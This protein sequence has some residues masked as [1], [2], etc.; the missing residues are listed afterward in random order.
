VAGEDLQPLGSPNGRR[1][2]LLGGAA[3]FVR[4][5]AEALRR[6]TEPQVV[7]TPEEEEE[8]SERERHDKLV[9][10]V[11]DC[12]KVGESA[13]QEQVTREL[14]DLNFELDQWPKEY[15]DERKGGF[16]PDGHTIPAKPCLEINKLDQPIGQVVNE[17]RMARLSI[18]IKPRGAGASKDVAMV[19][20]GLIRA[21]EV[22]SRAQIARLW[23]LDRAVKCGR[24][25]YRIAKRY[26]NDGDFDLDLVIERILNQHSV[27]FDPFAKEPDWSDGEWCVIFSDLPESEYRRRYPKSNLSRANADQLQTLGN[28]QPAWISGEVGKRAFRVAEFYY[29]VHEEVERVFIDGYGEAFL[30]DVPPQL[31]DRIRLRRKVDARHVEWCI[32]NAM[33]VLDEEAW[34]GR[35]IPVIPV[36]G[37]EYNVNGKRSWRGIISNAKDAQRSYNVMRSRQVE[38]IGLASLSTWVMAE[39]QDEGY[40]EQWDRANTSSFVRLIYKPT[41]FE[42][43]LTPA[44]SRDTAEPAI[45]AITQ[46]VREADNDIKATTGRYDPSLGRARAD[47]S[48]KAIRELKTQG[49]TGTSNYLANL[50]EYSMTYEGKVLNDMLEYVYDRPGRIVRLLGE[51]DEEREVMLNQPYQ[52][53]ATA[54]DAKQ[55]TPVP[56]AQFNP[57][58]HHFYNLKDGGQ[59]R[60]YVTVGPSQPSAREDD[61]Q[62]MN[63]LATAAP[64]LVPIYAD[65]WVRSNDSRVASQVADRLRRANP[66]AQQD[67]AAKKTNLPPEI[68]GQV[69]QM[70]QQL[71]E[72]AQQLQKLNQEIQTDKAK[73]DA[74]LQ[75]EREQNA[76]R[77]R[78][79]NLQIRKDLIIERAKLEADK[80]S[81]VF[82]AEIERLF[83]EAE[84]QHEGRMVAHE[85]VASAMPPPQPPQPPPP[86]PGM[87]GPPGPPPGPSRMPLGPPGPPM[88]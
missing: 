82:E 8:E 25:A 81:T 64:S 40:E 59:Y 14:D 43:Q 19:R 47:Q 60:V 46:A 4:P 83:L 30:K 70:Q 39:G 57:Q 50:A 1:L 67:D 35:Y 58:E 11:L 54:D 65:L 32:V 48:G 69:Q 56:Q 36:I 10:M 62:F 37:K 87:P 18:I 42:G 66:H 41:T 22:D 77:E 31:R 20:Q 52:E 29:V 72:A 76:S 15:R 7:A 2:D 55:L 33:E 21:I 84:Q 79:A 23:A 61:R 28:A 45:A 68:A 49:E 17:A 63:D 13:Y 24:G 12:T 27:I 38:A 85:A 16:T 75:I 74:Q 9:K 88:A 6:A 80:A 51:D 3:T 44:P 78:I 73:Y 5:D 26:A 53:T 71:Q 86:P 34:E